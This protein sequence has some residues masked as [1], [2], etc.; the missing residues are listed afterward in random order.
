MSQSAG[1]VL[2]PP[3]F[4]AGPPR[5]TAG[6]W[7]HCSP[8]NVLHYK[9]NVL[10]L[11]LLLFKG[12]KQNTLTIF[13]DAG[14]T[15]VMVKFP[16]RFLRS[17]RLPHQDASPWSK[18]ASAE[19]RVNTSILLTAAD[20]ISWFTLSLSAASGSRRWDDFSFIYAFIINFSISV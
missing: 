15:H 16:A 6:V 11:L 18:Q 19:S 13:L 7:N 9:S 5:P 14:L 20:N 17:V 10:L 3:P 8:L 4:M 2:I 12:K 1:S